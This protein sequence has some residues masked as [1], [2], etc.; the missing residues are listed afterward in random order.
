MKIHS[1]NKNGWA[2]VVDEKG[3]FKRVRLDLKARRK[4]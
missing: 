4:V 1:I 3:A 2:W